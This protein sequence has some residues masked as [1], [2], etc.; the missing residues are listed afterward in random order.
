MKQI[1]FLQVAIILTLQA[2]VVHFRNVVV[3][4]VGP[5]VN[6]VRTGGDEAVKE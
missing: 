4:Q 2:V 3:W 5:I 1:Q 6:N